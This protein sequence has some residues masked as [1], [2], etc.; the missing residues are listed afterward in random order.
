VIS[1]SVLLGAD[2]EIKYQPINTF[3]QILR[4]CGYIFVLWTLANHA[5]RN[6]GIKDNFY[7]TRFLISFANTPMGD[8]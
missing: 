3:S 6:L 7:L 5:I 4:S 2:Q 8:T 1:I